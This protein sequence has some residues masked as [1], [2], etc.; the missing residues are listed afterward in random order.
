MVKLSILFRRPA[1]VPEFEAFYNANLALMERIP[2]VLRRQVNVV[3]G[4]PGGESPYYRAL[5]LYFANYEALDRAMRSTEGE[6]AGRHL[7]AHAA[8]LV[9]LF[10]SE[11]YEEEGGSTPR[12]EEDT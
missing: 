7:M 5:E 8:E 9:E 3:L 11:V 6:A 2:G 12:P 4:A 10:F 1:S